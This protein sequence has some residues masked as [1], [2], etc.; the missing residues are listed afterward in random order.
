M[1]GFAEHHV[2]GARFRRGHGVM[3]GGE[4][5]DAG[6][7]FRLEKRQRLGECREAGQMR[8]VGAGARHQLGMA[9]D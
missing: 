6:D 4:A 5:A 7:A 8:A 9:V 1:S 3:A 2:V